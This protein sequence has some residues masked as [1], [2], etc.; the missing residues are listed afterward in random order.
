MTLEISDEHEG[1][2][3]HAESKNQPTLNLI[4]VPSLGESKRYL[5]SV[6]I[7]GIRPHF[8]ITSSTKSSPNIIATKHQEK[9]PETKLVFGHQLSPFWSHKTS[10]IRC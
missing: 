10:Y 5:G 3:R 7:P 2:L 9:Y 1:G 4:Y 6:L 8:L